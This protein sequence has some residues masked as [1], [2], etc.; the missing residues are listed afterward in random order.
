M[1]STL[2]IIEET[3]GGGSKQS[4]QVR[5]PERLTVRQLIGV[6]VDAQIVQH[7]TK[8]AVHHSFFIPAEDELI[9]NQKS[10][11][12][13]KSKP[14]DC[15]KLHVRALLGFEQ[16]QYFIL[17]DDTQAENLDQEIVLSS[18]SQVT[19]LRLTPLVGG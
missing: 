6:Y 2:T 17:I 9:L 18:Q 15:E 4:S 8:E 7:Q 14:L 3:P 19:F 12:S 5:L 13:A 1:S 16:N 10:H 11:S